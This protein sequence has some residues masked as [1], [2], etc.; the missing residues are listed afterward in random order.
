M[1]YRLA[2]D[3]VLLLHLAFVL[4]VVAGGFLVLKWPRLAWLHVP[5]ALWGALVEFTGWVCPLTPLESSL[6]VLGGASGYETDFIDQYL[7]PLLYPSALTR[8]VQVLLGAGV[9]LINALIYGKVWRR[10]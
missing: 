6:R 7:A 4:F 8:E 10:R 3:L 5:A 1:A 9:V 2:A